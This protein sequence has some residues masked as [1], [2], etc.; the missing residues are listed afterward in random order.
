MLALPR[1]AWHLPVA[2]N[3]SGL[4]LH[5]TVPAFIIS[6]AGLSIQPSSRASSNSGRFSIQATY[7]STESRTSSGVGLIKG[8]PRI[9]SNPYL[10]VEALRETNNGKIDE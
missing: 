2:R 8:V 5:S 4:V 6:S 9:V 7:A 10:A 3:V 1:Y